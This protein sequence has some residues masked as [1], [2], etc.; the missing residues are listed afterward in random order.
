MATEEEVQAVVEAEAR[1]PYCM[2]RVHPEARKCP[3]CQEYLDPKLA[4]ERLSLGGSYLS[5]ASFVAGL[6]GP[7]LMFLPGPVAVVLAMAALMRRSERRKGLA[8]VGLV[9]GLVWTAVLVLLA[10]KGLLRLPEHPGPAEPL[11]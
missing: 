7:F 2:E 9:L 5:V 8:I 6:F 3:H 1:C 10:T 11:F 4:K